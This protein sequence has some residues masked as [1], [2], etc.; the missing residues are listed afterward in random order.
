MKKHCIDKTHDPSQKAA[1]KASPF[2]FFE[3]CLKDEP[4][5]LSQKIRDLRAALPTANLE[6]IIIKPGEQFR[7]SGDMIV[8]DLLF[9]FP[10]I[11]PYLEDLHPLGL[12]SPQLDRTSLE[13][14]FSDQDQNLS[15]ICEGLDQ[16]INTHQV[17]HE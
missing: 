5:P 14:F 1:K 13:M 17:P 16:I 2:S 9:N 4:A 6:E 7:V 10:Q 12:L 8:A 15:L 11:R 3:C